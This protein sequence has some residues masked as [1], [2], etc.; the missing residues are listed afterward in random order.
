MI[1]SWVLFICL[2]VTAVSQE[3][4]PTLVTETNANDGWGFVMMSTQVS[5]ADN[6]CAQF[7]QT[8]VLSV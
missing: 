6:R 7:T 2:N 1:F 4:V 3:D 5:S 8:R